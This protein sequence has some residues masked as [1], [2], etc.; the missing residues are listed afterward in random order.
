M[1]VSFP[2]QAPVVL[3]FLA[4]CILAAALPASAGQSFPGVLMPGRTA[5]M[6]AKYDDRV[7]RV[8]VR[9]GSRV[10]KGQLLI[11]LNDDEAAA[12]RDRAAALLERAKAQFVRA[13]KL[14]ADK[15]ISDAEY[16]RVRADHKI[17]L[18]DLALARVHVSERALR[19]PFD[20]LV[21]DLYTDEGASLKEGD[22]LVRV[23]ALNPLRVEALLPEEMLSRLA[24]AQRVRVTLASPETTLWLPAPHA[25]LAVD[26]A[27]GMFPLH[28]EVGN[29]R[30]RLIPG[31]SCKIE[32]PPRAG[33]GP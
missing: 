7:A 21:A 18:A 27:S 5:L 16:E 31:V 9:V 30:G 4:G 22:P 19:A 17:A 2:V 20:G 26:P 29:A 24:S 1:R 10:R 11:Q 33:S 14:H 12:E 15:S 6:K 3:C 8:P 28:L 32:L 23:T 25:A 13:E